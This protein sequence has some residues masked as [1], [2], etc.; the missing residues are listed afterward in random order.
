MIG[1]SIVFDC[2]DH[3]I[4]ENAIST[5]VRS[6]AAGQL[7]VLPTDTLYGIGAD[8]FDATAVTE[9]LAAKGRG[10]DMPVPVLVGS[11]DTID[12]L[13]SFVPSQTRSLIEAFWP[14]D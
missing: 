5:A 2:S 4:R 14:G 9:L 7:I 3:S 11:W 10:R 1:V 12:G 6:V 8:A 13:V